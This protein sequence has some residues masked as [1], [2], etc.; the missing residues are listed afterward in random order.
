MGIRNSMEAKAYL[1]TG[2]RISWGD[3]DGNGV[4][5]G[6]LPETA[7]EITRAK[8]ITV[9]DSLDEA[10]VTSRA[11]GGTKQTRGT[12]RE[13]EATMTMP[14]DP[15]DTHYKT[16]MTAYLGRTTVPIAFLTGDGATAGNTG[17]WA[18]WMV[19]SADN[20]QALNGAQMV[21][22]TFAPGESSVPP[23]EVRTTV[24]A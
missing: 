23:E 11:S 2:S 6:P 20:D 17:Y 16:I 3:D 10:D 24:G 12:L 21:T 7:E 19:A 4:I 22:F 14:L 15:T 9:N 18:D 8:D 13:L 1:D 5:E